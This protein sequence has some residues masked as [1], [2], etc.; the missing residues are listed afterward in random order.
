MKLFRAEGAPR[1]VIMIYYDGE[2]SH[3]YWSD[4][5]DKGVLDQSTTA[6]SYD[7]LFINLYHVQATNFVGLNFREK[8]QNRIF[9]L[10][11]S[12]ITKVYQ[13]K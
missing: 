12:R 5:K 11:I 3:S 9:A 2:K 8:L 1:V 13:R 4:S 6:S 7:K 10:F